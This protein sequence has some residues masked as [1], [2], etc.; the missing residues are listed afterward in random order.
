VPRPR[1]ENMPFGNLKPTVSFLYSTPDKLRDRRLDMVHALESKYP[2]RFQS[3]QPVFQMVF[4]ISDFLATACETAPHRCPINAFYPPFVSY[5][6]VSKNSKVFP[7][8]K[9]FPNPPFSG[10]ISNWK[11]KGDTRCKWPKV[12]RN[13]PF[14]DLENKII[15]RGSDFCFLPNIYNFQE[16]NNQL[17]RVF[18]KYSLATRS[19]RKIMEELM[20]RYNQ[21]TPRWKAVVL[22]LHE[23]ILEDRNAANAW[24][25]ALFSGS[26]NG[27]AHQLLNER[28]FLVSEKDSMDS[29]AMCKYKYQIDLGGGE[30]K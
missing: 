21:L 6:T 30:C 12:D 16:N 10:C 4:T 29:V 26:A 28:G 17:Q 20:N 13:I 23:R 19:D 7:T 24:I 9:A 18:S 5:S 1:L 15:W 11:L 8:A 3:G 14:E 22:S 2:H 27:E 25:D